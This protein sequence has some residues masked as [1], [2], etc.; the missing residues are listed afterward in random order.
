MKLTVM[1]MNQMSLKAA[2]FLFDLFCQMV[3]TKLLYFDNFIGD[4]LKII[5]AVI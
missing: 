3:L 2:R 1:M 4:D 5:L